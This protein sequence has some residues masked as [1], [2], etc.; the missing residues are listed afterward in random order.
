MPNRAQLQIKR[1]SNYFFLTHFQGLER[2]L[3][4][5]QLEPKQLEYPGHIRG[6][7]AFGVERYKV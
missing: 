4:F 3:A 7:H 5:T 6:F 2:T 1:S